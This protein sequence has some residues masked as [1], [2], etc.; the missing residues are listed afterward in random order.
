MPV[1]CLPG[2]GSTCPL[3]TTETCL[4]SLPNVPGAK[5]FQDENDLL[6]SLANLLVDSDLR[7]RLTQNAYQLAVS[8]HNLAGV[9]EDFKMKFINVVSEYDVR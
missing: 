6:E 5:S 9:S 4:Q 2:A 1:F 3:V 8:K 7:N